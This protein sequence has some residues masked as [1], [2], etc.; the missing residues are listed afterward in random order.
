M[1]TLFQ[2]NEDPKS[3]QSKLLEER[4]IIGEEQYKSLSIG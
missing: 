3:D 1:T 4:A 2:I